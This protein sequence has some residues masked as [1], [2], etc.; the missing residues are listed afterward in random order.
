[1][2]FSLHNKLFHS[3]TCLFDTDK[4]IKRLWINWILFILL[5]GVNLISL[6]SNLPT[7]HQFL[8]N[9]MSEVLNST[10]TS[11]KVS[12]LKSP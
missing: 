2:T 3:V 6:V 8:T 10:Q 4:E 9:P 7:Q 11:L 12:N 1:M 5:G